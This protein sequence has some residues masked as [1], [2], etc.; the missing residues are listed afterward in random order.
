MIS[1]L[2][3]IEINILPLVI[4]VLLVLVSIGII[5]TSQYIFNTKHYIGI[6]C[7]ALS[8]LL[9]FVNKK[10]YVIF[11]TLTLTMG[12]LG[13]LDFF[14]TT[15]KVGFAGAGIN[16]IFLGLII[17]LLLVSKEQMRV[18]NSKDAEN[19]E[20]KLNEALINSFLKDFNAKTDLELNE[21]A[22]NDSKY[23][24]EAKSA[25]LRV[26]ESRSRIKN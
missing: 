12:L 26:L 7:L 15:F 19:S 14:I 1:K 16:P 24:D 4:S 6:A 10:F 9:Y 23:T 13:L 8:T 21:I 5:M 3:K 11:F 22:D 2:R 25:A 17:M 18:L 20:P